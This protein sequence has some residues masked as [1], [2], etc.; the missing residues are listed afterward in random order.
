MVVQPDSQPPVGLSSDAEE[1]RRAGFDPGDDVAQQIR[2]M[3]G[4][5]GYDVRGIDPTIGADD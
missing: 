4:L 3:A 1:M 5:D 2:A